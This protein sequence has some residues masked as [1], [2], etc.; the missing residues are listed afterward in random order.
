[1][2][3]PEIETALLGLLCNASPGLTKDD[4][5]LEISGPFALFRHTRIYARA[6]AS[7][8]PRLSWCHKLRL[9]ADCVLGTGTH[10]GC[11]ELRTGD[12]VI[13]A[14][15]LAPFDS[16]VEE[17]FAKSFGKLAPEWDVVREPR[18]VPVDDALIFPD[19]ELRHR[20]TGDS[21]LLEIAGYWTPDRRKLDPKAV[22]SIIDPTAA[23]ALP[24][25]AK[26]TRKR[27]GP[28]TPSE[29]PPGDIAPPP[30]P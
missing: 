18:A 14:R 16:K 29:Q 9:E 20:A 24:P 21:W 17:R 1:M 2:A 15:E 7:L 5:T 13:P 25:A 23:K 11:L 4:L 12:P 19:F 3:A 10:I 22:L 8:I 27:L 26:R 6:L 30:G 28:K